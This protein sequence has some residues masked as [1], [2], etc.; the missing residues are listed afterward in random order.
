MARELPVGR[1]TVSGL[2]T[3]GGA[4]KAT[5]LRTSGHKCTVYRVVFSLC[6]IC[7]ST[8]AKMIALS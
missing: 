4:T 5:E 8:L 3:S 2:S 1:A 6:N 7:P